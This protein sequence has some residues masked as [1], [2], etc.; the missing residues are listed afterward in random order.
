MRECIFRYRGRQKA[1]VERL[2]ATARPGALFPDVRRVNAWLSLSHGGR[3][4]PKLE[5]HALSGF[6]TARA[7]WL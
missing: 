5:L 7:I 2:L 1:H 3:A 4:T 6:P